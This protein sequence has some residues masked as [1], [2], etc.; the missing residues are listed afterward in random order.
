MGPGSLRIQTFRRVSEIAMA[1][2]VGQIAVATKFEKATTGAEQIAVV[3]PTTVR[4]CP[5]GSATRT[6]ENEYA[7]IPTH[8]VTIDIGNIYRHFMKAKCTLHESK[9]HISTIN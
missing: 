7:Y 6:G 4:K 3:T 5:C 9:M 1:T 8:D 2:Q